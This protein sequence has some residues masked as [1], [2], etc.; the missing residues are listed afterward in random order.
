[1]I[2]KKITKGSLLILQGFSIIQFKLQRKV[3]NDMQ[4]AT[5]WGSAIVCPKSVAVKNI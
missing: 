2:T 3:E 1:V 5:A 4:N